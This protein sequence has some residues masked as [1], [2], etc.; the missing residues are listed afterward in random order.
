[1]VSIV[2]STIAYAQSKGYTRLGLLGTI[3]TMENDFYQEGFE[4]AGMEII[5]PMPDERK[6]IHKIYMDELVRGPV[7]PRNEKPSAF[8]RQ[9]DVPGRAN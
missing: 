2:D 1:M 8:N 7:S 5:T 6:Y 4:A 3:T 9:P